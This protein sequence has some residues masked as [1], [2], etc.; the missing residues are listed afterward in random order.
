MPNLFQTPGV[1][2]EEISNLIS[3]DT[4]ISISTQGF[5]Y[6]DGIINKKISSK[7]IDI[8]DFRLYASLSPVK[9]S[10]SNNYQPKIY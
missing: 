7:F 10:A 6:Q 8:P 2:I 3:L 5:S 1:Y 9:Q 4:L